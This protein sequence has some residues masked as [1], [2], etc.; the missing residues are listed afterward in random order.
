M[1]LAEEARP[2]SVRHIYYRAVAA[3][4][5]PKDE[6]GYNKV[7]YD[8]GIL[9]ETGRIPYG[10]IVDNGRRGHFPLVSRSPESALRALAYAYR[11]DPWQE[12]GAPEVE[13]WCESRS[14]AGVL[15]DLKLSLIHI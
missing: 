2:A 14:I 8:L 5:V 6:R 10:W 4:I 13:I 12:T 15:M 9:R 11:R 1:A 3:G 7:V